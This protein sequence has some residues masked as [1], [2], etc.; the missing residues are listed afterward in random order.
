MCASRG[1]RQ[2]Q[3]GWSPYCEPPSCQRRNR[4]PFAVSPFWDAIELLTITRAPEEGENFDVGLQ[5]SGRG[6]KRSRLQ[7]GM[8]VG[9][10]RSEIRGLLSHSSSAV[11]KNSCAELSYATQRTL[12]L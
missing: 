10:P 1:S 7:F 5:A 4:L 3:T 6:V 8:Q 12:G 2:V 9:G 11:M